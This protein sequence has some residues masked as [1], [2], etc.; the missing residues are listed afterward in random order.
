MGG[1]AI[2]QL[3]VDLLRV[4]EPLFS[5][6][7][8]EDEGELWETSD[9]QLV[10]EHIENTNRAIAAYLAEH[11]NAQSQV[12]MPGGRW[13]SLSGDCVASCL[14]RPFIVCLFGRYCRIKPL[15][16]SFVPRSQEW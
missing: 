2:H 12:K 10:E 7:T 4:V 8:V 13:F 1:P 11:P 5:E 15:V 9:R 16:F 14:R 6:F 3:V